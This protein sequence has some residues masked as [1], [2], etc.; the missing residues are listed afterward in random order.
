MPKGK[1]GKKPPIAPVPSSVP[2]S[3]AELG[4]AAD[5]VQVGK[6]I[7]EARGRATQDEFARQLGVHANTLGRYER[8][9]RLPDADFIAAMAEK[10]DI[11][12]HWLL[13]GIP[14]QRLSESVHPEIRRSEFWKAYSKGLA[15]EL[16]IKQA[17]ASGYVYIPLYD[18]RAAAGGGSIV[19][20]EHVVDV[21]AFKEDWIRQELRAAPNDLRLIFVEGDSMEPD[22]RAGDI[23][24]ID[25]TDTTAR[26]EGIYVIRMDGALLVKQLQRLPGGV[27]KVLSRNQA[28]ESFTIPVAQLEERDGFAVI[29]R[30]V[31]ACR[32]F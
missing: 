5:P 26:R 7:G 9:E 14:P 22:L 23:V 13:Y 29:G 20:N 30:V 27:L 31:W 24:L 28:Y 4:T 19:E 25:H 11:S 3:G 21:L 12:T 32:R 15:T 17:A 16:H 8:G 10:A 2:G 1:T 18:V 6:R